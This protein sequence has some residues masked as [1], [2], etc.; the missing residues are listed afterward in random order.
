MEKSKIYLWRERTKGKAI[1][2][3][4]KDISKTNEGFLKERDQSLA[5]HQEWFEWDPRG[6]GQKWAAENFPMIKIKISERANV[7]SAARYK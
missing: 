3:L 4:C 1:E 5:H 2:Y 6:K 7:I